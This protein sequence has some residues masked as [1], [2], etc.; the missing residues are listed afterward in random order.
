[1]FAVDPR[2]SLA[3]PEAERMIFLAGRN[4]L[5]RSGDG[6]HSWQVMQRNGGDMKTAGRVRTI[7]FAAGDA[8]TLYVGTADGRIYRPDDAT[9]AAPSWR[10]IAPLYFKKGNPTGGSL[11][12]SAIA[13]SPLDANDVWVT[14]GGP[15]VSATHRPEQVLNPSGISHVF[16]STD[17]GGSWRDVSGLRGG[18]A[19]PDAPT[20][21]VAVTDLHRDIAFVGTD[22]GV[23]WTV[24]GGVT[25]SPL[26]ERL[27]TCPV[28]VLRYGRRHRRLYAATMGRGVYTLDLP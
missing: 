15:G 2:P 5:V 6:G 3:D 8:T 10:E 23:F 9:A 20:C 19:L 1:V 27:P 17:G 7:E 21:A 13:V 12:I 26:Q 11:P 4:E 28:T 16:R 25:W 14:L 22:I 24:D 18:K